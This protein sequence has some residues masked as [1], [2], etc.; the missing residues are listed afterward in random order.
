MD[1]L[2]NVTPIVG[3]CNCSVLLYVALCPFLFCN[4]LDGGD[5]VGNFA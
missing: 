2:F 1:M 5:G 3:V 4:H